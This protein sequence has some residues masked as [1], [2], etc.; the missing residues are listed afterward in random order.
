L[1]PVKLSKEQEDIIHLP[2]KG[3]TFLEGIP[4]SGK[5]TAGLQR[6][7]Q[8]ISSG[9]PPESIIVLVPQ[10]TLALPYYHALGKADLPSGGMV[11]IVTMGGMAQHMIE[12]FWPLISIAAGFKQSIRQPKFLTLETAQYYLEKIIGPFIE[13]GYFESIKIDHN[14]L[15]SQIID[16]LNKAAVIGFPHTSFGERLKNA[17]IGEPGQRHV[18]EEAQECANEFRLFCLNKNLLDFSLQ[19]EIFVKFLWPS[20]ICQSYLKN[21]YRH[22]IYDNVEEDVPIVHDIVL[23]WL[24]DFESALF[25]YDVDGGYRSFLGADSQSGY[26]FKKACDHVMSFSNSQILSNDMFLL[27]DRIQ[28]KILSNKTHESRINVNHTLELSTPRFFPQMIN[29]IV[30]RIADLINLESAKPEDFVIL[31]PYLSDSLRFTLANEM[32]LIG[33]PFRSHR[34]SRSLLEEPATRCLLTLSKIAHP[35]WDL[36][37]SQFDFRYAL[38]QSISKLDL[39]RSDLLSKTLYHPDQ[40]EKGLGSFTQLNS[41]M[42]MRISFTFGNLYESLRLWLKQYM[43]GQIVELDIFLSRLFGEI[44]SQPGFGFSTDLDKAS[45]AARLL[46][47]IK[48]FRIISEDEFSDPALLG[49]EYIAMIE[50][51]ILA[52]QYLPIWEDNEESAVLLSPAYTYLMMNRP[53]KY[54][55]WLDIGSISW[56]ERIYQPLTHPYVLN[57]NWR[58]GEIWTD[59]HEFSA[60]Q[61]SM[62]R[63]VTGLLRRCTGKVFLYTAM[64]N[65]QGRD[66]KGPLIRCLNAILKGSNIQ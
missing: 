25:I 2:L 54:Q 30:Q 7:I 14:H 27:Q 13:K 39:I 36:K 10:R 28:Q 40:L 33:I 37:P 41:E 18:F 46:D 15:L 32:N 47:S 56:W 1:K 22:L 59:I 20:F 65:E 3:S 16:N 58:D 53:A 5:T 11:Q 61:A 49:K 42:K 24:S 34:P 31:A 29:D 64:V 66:E 9:I 62:A 44:L 6:V 12:L 45:I 38:M 43:E 21:R 8:L 60:N 17:C 26:Q 63:L 50:S 4:G 51:G 23:D 52:A 19:I 57:R 35:T 55:F 48:N